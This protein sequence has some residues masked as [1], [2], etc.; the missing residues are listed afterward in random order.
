MFD[1]K[2]ATCWALRKPSDGDDSQAIL[3]LGSAQHLAPFRQGHGIETWGRGTRLACTI[4]PL[5]GARTEGERD[6]SSCA[7]GH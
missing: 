4:V 1:L 2:C 3:H 5:A 6:L 7:C